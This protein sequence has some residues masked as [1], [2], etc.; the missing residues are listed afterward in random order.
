MV[1]DE[2]G[3]EGGKE[4]GLEAS[5]VRK[6]AAGYLLS[7]DIVKDRDMNAHNHHEDGNGTKPLSKA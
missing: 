6:E 4:A 7:C 5:A 3:K 1:L 2:R